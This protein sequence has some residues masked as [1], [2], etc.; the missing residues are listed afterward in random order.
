M[1][2]KYSR[3][4]TAAR[5]KPLA[6]CI[7]ALFGLSS[8][9][10]MAILPSTVFVDTC[11][12][13]VSTTDSTHGS[14]RW[15]STHVADGGT[16]DMTAIPCSLISLQ[17]GSITLAQN[18][19]TIHGP[20]LTNLT[21]SAELQANGKKYYMKDRIFK[22][23]GTGTLA[24]Y[25]LTVNKGYYKSAAGFPKGGCIYSSGTVNLT[26]VGAYSCSVRTDSGTARGGAVSAQGDVNLSY[27]TVSVNNAYSGA[28]GFSDGGGVYALGSLTSIVS[29]IK[30]NKATGPTSTY[31]GS[32]GG[33]YVLGSGLVLAS[34][35]SGNTATSRVGGALFRSFT[36][37][38]EVVLIDSTISGNSSSGYVGGIYSNAAKTYLFSST[39][40]FNTA[41]NG[42]NSGLAKYYSP[43]FA[44]SSYFGSM[45]INLQSSLLS[46]N[47]YGTTEKDLTTAD[48]ILGSTHTTTFNTSAPNVVR[49]PKL[50]GLGNLPAGTITGLCPLLGQLR[51]NGGPTK[52]HALL[53]RSIAID[54]G[55]N[56]FSLDSFDQRGSPYL[57]P[58][59]VSGLSDIGA[60]E[61]QQDD[62]VFNGGFDGC[63]AL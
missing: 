55:T 14:L 36:P 1:S 20:G 50:G 44:T 3:S 8:P 25:D 4:L 22:H 27:S 52:T 41:T 38:P 47:T 24:I 13:G 39:V 5:H 12:E 42:K 15:A 57:R 58:D 49:Q 29:N 21:V 61:V 54:A 2:S 60:Y 17:T 10:A 46:N 32:G 31:H 19:L 53:S 63:P 23:A 37:A 33:L 34:T 45:Y 35:I 62:I 11:D 40:A 28:T 30:Y 16:I 9:A 26:R 43:G 56:P 59:S 7:A 48:G 18:D 51:N 6:A